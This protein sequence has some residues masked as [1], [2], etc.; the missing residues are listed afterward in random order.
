M[1]PGFV[2]AHTHPVFGATRVA[3]YELRSE[4]ATYEQI[5][6]SGGGIRSTVRKTREASEDELTEAAKRRTQWFLR[7]GTT[8]EAKSGYI[9]SS[10]PS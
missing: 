3:E 9:L 6:A 1:L 5:A 4:G 7:N 2:D 10:N 8:L